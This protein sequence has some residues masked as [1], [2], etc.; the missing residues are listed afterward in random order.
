[1]PDDD[2]TPMTEW[3]T[4]IRSREIPGSKFYPPKRELVSVPKRSD[5]ARGS[6][7]D[8]LGNRGGR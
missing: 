5:Y 7:Q 1:M 6:Y 3:G 8:R 2:D 4:P